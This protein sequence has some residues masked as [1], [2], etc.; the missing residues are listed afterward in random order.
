MK[1]NY[2]Y[3]FYFFILF[4]LLCFNYY[5]SIQLIKYFVTLLTIKSI[6]VISLNATDTFNMIITLSFLLTFIMILPFLMYK[7]W[8]YIKDALYIREHL[9]IKSLKW[10][11]F[12][13][14]LGVI[15]GFKLCIDYSLPYFLNYHDIIG[16]QPTTGL[17]FA[18]FFLIKNMITFLILFQLPLLIINLIYYDIFLIQEIKKYRK[19]LYV[20]SLV[21]GALLTPQDPI[22]MIIVAL[23]IILLL[24]I[25][26]II[27]FVK[28]KLFLNNKT[29]L[30]IKQLYLKLKNYI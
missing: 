7:L 17:D 2:K 1:S 28:K 27:A 16:L 26:L 18:V 24:E 21:L 9:F 5:F 15:F 3:F 22:S 14:I 4:I 20:I 13:S 6:K 12:L 19:H 11:L 29:Y 8:I 25:G 10:S 23:P 30:K